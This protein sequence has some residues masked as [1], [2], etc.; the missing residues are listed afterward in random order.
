M[1][2]IDIVEWST[3]PKTFISN[4]LN[5]AKVQKIEL[6]EDEKSAK[7]Y[8]S[9]KDLSLAIGKEG[10]NVRLAVKMTGWK[11]DLVPEGGVKQAEKEKTAKMKVHELAKE[12][13]ITSSELIAKLR[14][15]GHAVKAANSSV[16]EKA[17]AE[18]RESKGV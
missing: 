11:I 13:G 12:L 18:L 3:D 5:P 1:E 6:K 4:S 9:E 14:E 17:V 15:K 2:R 10:Q 7:V 16:P 8:V